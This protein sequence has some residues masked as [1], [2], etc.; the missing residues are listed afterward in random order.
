MQNYQ[1]LF[2]DGNV[3]PALG[4]TVKFGL[5]ALPVGIA[6]PL[7]LALLMNIA[8]VGKPLPHDVLLSVHHPLCGGDLCVG[9]HA[10]PR[11]RLDQPG[12]RGLGV[13]IRPTGSKTP[14]GSIPRW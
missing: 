6:L 8:S 9:G 4:V 5:I 11:N 10:Q 12:L 1:T 14:P 7:I 13:R 2:S 3:V